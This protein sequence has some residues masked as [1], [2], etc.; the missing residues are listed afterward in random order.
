MLEQL[1]EKNDLSSRRMGKDISHLRE[2]LRYAYTTVTYY[3]F[4]IERYVLKMVEE[5]SIKVYRPN[6]ERKCHGSV[7]DTL[8]DAV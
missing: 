6:V 3:N 2:E 5:I 4:M 8:K 7:L 1:V